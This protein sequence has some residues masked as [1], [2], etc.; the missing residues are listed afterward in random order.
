MNALQAL[1]TLDA[2]CAILQCE[3]HIIG[4]LIGELNGYRGERADSV[5][6]NAFDTVTVCAILAGISLRALLARRTYF[7]RVALFALNTLLT[8]GAL[9]ALWTL[10][11]TK[12]GAT[13]R[14]NA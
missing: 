13:H 12:S 8:L 9:L 2:L 3:D 11:A 7:A 1:N 10:I 6:G 4:C 14:G 5:G